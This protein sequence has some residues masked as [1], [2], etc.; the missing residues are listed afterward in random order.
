MKVFA[1]DIRFR[2]KYS[3]A[4]FEYWAFWSC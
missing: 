4:G 3:T 1:C 2:H